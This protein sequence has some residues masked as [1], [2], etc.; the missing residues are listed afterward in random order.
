MLLLKVITMYAQFEEKTYEQYLTS[1][2]VHNRQ[3]F[4]PPGQVLENIVGFDVAL[5]TSNHTFWKLFPHMSRWWQR[6]FFIYPSGICLMHE[7]WQKLEHEIEYFPKFKFNC[8][9]QAKRPNRMIGFNS[10]EYSLWKQPY[11]RYDIFSNQQKALESLAQKTS[12]KAIVVYA[13]P[14]FH[15]YKELWSAINT[16]Q[17]VKQSNF[18]EVAKLNGHSRYSF[19]SAGNIGIAHSEPTPIE[20]KSFEKAL[21]ELHNQ[22]PRQSN[23]AFL[24]ETA[25]MVV[26]AS[27]QLGELR[28]TYVSLAETLF[29]EADSKLARLLAKIYAFQFVCNVQFL[30]GYEMPKKRQPHSQTK[31]GLKTKKRQSHS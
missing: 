18:C 26:I 22:E 31:K 12:G 20:S 3:L 11:F 8:F 30:I 6:M 21:E 13:C 4:F 24:A 27:E 10:Q 16:R 1:E 15:T 17:L 28:E 7:W 19:A 23:S 2:L 5:R 25:E 14:A 29:K 9:I